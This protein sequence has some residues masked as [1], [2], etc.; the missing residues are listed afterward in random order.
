MYGHYYIVKRDGTVLPAALTRKGECV[1][2]PEELVLAEERLSA[3]EADEIREAVR[4]GEYECERLP[5]K[6]LRFNFHPLPLPFHCA[7]GEV[8][9]VVSCYLGAERGAL[10]SYTKADDGSHVPRAFGKSMQSPVTQ[11]E[12]LRLVC[13]GIMEL[14]SVRGPLPGCVD[15]WGYRDEDG[16][17]LVEAMVRRST[18]KPF[19]ALRKSARI[20]RRRN[21]VWVDEE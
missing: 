9:R 21:P 1:V 11:M 15:S 14:F 18:K 12:L 19:V 10:V 20:A 17:V 7:E 3:E 2:L 4:G 13:G 5:D 16:D 8:M 6:R